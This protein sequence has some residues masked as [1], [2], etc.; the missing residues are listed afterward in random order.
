MWRVAS[1]ACGLPTSKSTAAKSRSTRQEV[2]IWPQ[3]LAVK[4]CLFKLKRKTFLQLEA[5][6]SSN[7]NSFAAQAP[8]WE[9]VQSSRIGSPPINFRMQSYAPKQSAASCWNC[10]HLCCPTHWAPAFLFF[11]LVG[12]TL[13]N[14]MELLNN[15]SQPSY[16]WTYSRLANGHCGCESELYCPFV[17]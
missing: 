12:G 14:R 15:F 7:W 10:F 11:F 5:E 4:V 9:C 6:V 1:L 17:N 13:K 3:W 2:Y 16:F 8:L